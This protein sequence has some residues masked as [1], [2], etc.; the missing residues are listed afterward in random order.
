M[1]VFNEIEENLQTIRSKEI[2]IQKNAGSLETGHDRVASVKNDIRAIDELMQENKNNLKK[3]SGKLKSEKTENKEMKRMIDNMENI[4]LNKDV[5]IMQLVGDLENLN[6]QVKELYTSVADL[7][8]ENIEQERVI[9][10]Q[11]MQLNAAYYIIGEEKDLKSKGIITKKGGFIGIG[12]V[13]KMMEDVDENLFTKI[14]IRKTKVFPI[15]AKKVKLIT[16][17]PS[18]SYIVRKNDKGRYYSFE[19]TKPEIFWGKSKVMI[20]SLKK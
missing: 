4:I 10:L 13:E 2:L 19:I 6:I 7:K 12:R 15:D 3:L 20:L 9:G 1:E 8:A 14:D 17:H 18:D 16:S 5:E 11:E